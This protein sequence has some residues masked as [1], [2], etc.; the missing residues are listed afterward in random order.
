MVILYITFTD[1]SVSSS[2]SS[3]RPKKIYDAFKKNGHDVILISGDDFITHDNSKHKKSVAEANEWLDSNKPDICYV[4]NATHPLFLKE[5][6]KI[7]KRVHDLGIPIGYFYRDCYYRYP[8]VFGSGKG[9]K[10]ELVY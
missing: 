2:G 6:R 8:E 5:D 4:E 9:L 10:N 3:V 7:I 1:F